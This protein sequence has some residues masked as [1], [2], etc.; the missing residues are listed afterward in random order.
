MSYDSLSLK[1]LKSFQFMK[2]HSFGAFIPINIIPMFYENSMKSNRG[3]HSVKYFKEN[4]LITGHIVDM[5]NKEQYDIFYDEND[6]KEYEEWDHENIAF[7]C[8]GN[9]FEID[10]PFQYNKGPYS[11]RER[12]LYGYPI[13]HYMI[14]MPY[15]FWKNIVL[16]KNILKLLLIKDMK[17]WEIFLHF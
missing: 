17:K 2:Y 5:C 16:I 7:L 15:N 13:Y 9:Y 6:E 10:N 12:Y 8:D 1:K 4:G 3:I 14:D 11:I